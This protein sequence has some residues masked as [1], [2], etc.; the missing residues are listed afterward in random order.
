MA[1]SDTNPLTRITRVFYIHLRQAS[2][3]PN[4]QRRTRL[5]GGTTAPAPEDSTFKSIPQERGATLPAQAKNA[6]SS[7]QGPGSPFPHHPGDGKTPWPYR[8]HPAPCMGDCIKGDRSIHSADRMTPMENRLE[9]R[10]ALLEFGATARGCP[11][12]IR[13]CPFPANLDTIS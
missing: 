10:A 4:P 5:P 9:R 2:H 3:H 8:S 7:Y 1:K 13:S 12:D 11:E 6:I